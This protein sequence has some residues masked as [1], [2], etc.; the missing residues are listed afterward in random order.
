MALIIKPLDRSQGFSGSLAKHPTTVCRMYQHDIFGNSKPTLVLFK[1][2]RLNQLRF[3]WHK[4]YNLTYSFPSELF[5]RSISR[6]H[7]K[8]V[9]SLKTG[10]LSRRLFALKGGKGGGCW[11]THNQLS[12]APSQSGEEK[13]GGCRKGVALR[14]WS[15]VSDN[16][17]QSTYKYELALAIALW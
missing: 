1:S 2:F 4:N 13:Q 9:S 17:L 12:E 3:L 16:N 8:C 10:T 5:L 7:D 6:A 14:R 15:R 11:G